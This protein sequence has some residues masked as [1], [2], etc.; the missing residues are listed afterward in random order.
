MFHCA[1]FEMT[2]WVILS[3]GLI[4][5]LY[6]AL[7]PFWLY[8]IIYSHGAE[9]CS[10]CKVRDGKSTHAA[11]HALKEILRSIEKTNIL[12]VF[13]HTHTHKTPMTFK[14]CLYSTFPFFFTLLR[15]QIVTISRLWLSNLHTAFSLPLREVV[16]KP[17]SR[18][19]HF[20]VQD[21][22]PG[23]LWVPRCEMCIYMHLCASIHIYFVWR[24]LFIIYL[25]SCQKTQRNSISY[26]VVPNTRK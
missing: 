6:S 23:D 12:C 14:R 9:K 19:L 17:S 7:A 26:F 8:C 21:P 25:S 13:K 11:S 2:L 1:L 3:K 4:E 20:S 15:K 10:Y 24:L 16:I 18:L 22:Y 5:W